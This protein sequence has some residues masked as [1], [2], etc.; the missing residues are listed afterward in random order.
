MPV[1]GV[2]YY[3]ATPYTIKMA[4]GGAYLSPGLGFRIAINNLVQ[5]IATAEYS[6]ETSQRTLTEYVAGKPHDL[7]TKTTGVN[8]FKINIGI[9]FQKK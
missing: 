1:Y 5:I 6:Y 3:G 8:F 9:G 7:P 4:G 2:H